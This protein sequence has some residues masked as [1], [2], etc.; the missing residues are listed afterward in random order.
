MSKEKLEQNPQDSRKSKLI[1]VTS[2][3]AGTGKSTVAA[4]VASALAFSG[5]RTII[6]ELGHSLRCQDIMLGVGKSELKHDIVQYLGSK[7]SGGE[8]LELL[9]IAAKVNEKDDNLYLVCASLQPFA[10]SREL[11]NAGVLGVCEELR[12]HF[13][14]VVIDTASSGSLS[15]PGSAL[16]VIGIAD[17]VVMV[18]TPDSDCVSDCAALSDLLHIRGYANQHLLINKATPKSGDFDAVMDVVGIPLIGVLPEDKDVKICTAK[19]IPLPNGSYSLREYR[20]IAERILG[21]YVPLTIKNI[22]IK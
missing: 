4:N 16:A 11:D 22:S 18:T 8:S 2:G 10:S 6:V 12:E 14:Y 5:K 7:K 3:K 21:K 9:E 20:A 17:E 13:D 15:S 19:G 1:A